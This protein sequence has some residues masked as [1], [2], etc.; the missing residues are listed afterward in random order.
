VTPLPP[1]LYPH[2][3]TS[4]ASLHIPNNVPGE[5]A[6]NV[7]YYMFCRSAPSI[8]RAA[9]VV[10]TCFSRSELAPSPLSSE[11]MCTDCRALSTAS[12]FLFNGPRARPYLP[13]LS[14]DRPSN[15]RS[16]MLDIERLA[17]LCPPPSVKIK[18]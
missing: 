6:Y 14:E 8:R 3:G 2:E 5:T 13:N 15:D 1:F 7:F 9:H 10:P 11:L 18:R 16:I 4:F 12:S 17:F